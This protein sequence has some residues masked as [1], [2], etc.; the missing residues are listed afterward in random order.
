MDQFELMASASCSGQIMG[1]NVVTHNGEDWR[2]HRK[3]TAPAFDG[4]MCVWFGFVLSVKKRVLMSGGSYLDVWDTSTRLY[5]EMLNSE[6]WRSGDSHYF[7]DI[8]VF[9]M[10]VSICLMV[11]AFLRLDEFACSDFR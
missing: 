9:T 11:T 6:T 1:P 4:Q 10:R 3:I 5:Y 7:K 8:G 2:R